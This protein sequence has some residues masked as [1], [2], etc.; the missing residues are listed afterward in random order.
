MVAAG[1]VRVAAMAFGPGSIYGGAGCRGMKFRWLPELA[2]QG[3]PRFLECGAIRQRTEQRLER[4]AI[5][6]ERVAE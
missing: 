3:G 4:G 6:K 2:H 1:V 5:E